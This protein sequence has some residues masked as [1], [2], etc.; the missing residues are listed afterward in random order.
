MVR[1]MREGTTQVGAVFPVLWLIGMHE[2]LVILDR[3]GV[4][5]APYA[6]YLL[7]LVSVTSSGVPVQI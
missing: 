3:S 4:K 1:V 5:V 7:M 6:D 2:I